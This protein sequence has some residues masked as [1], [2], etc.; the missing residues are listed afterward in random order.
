MKFSWKKTGALILAV[1]FSAA[2]SGCSGGWKE[3]NTHPVT[4]VSV[5]LPHDSDQYWEYIRLSLEEKKEEAKNYNIDINI[6]KPQMNY[7]ISQ[8]TEIL[9]KQIAAKADFIVVQGN[10]DPEFNEVLLGAW[11]EGIHIVCV[12]T[13][14]E[15]FPEHLY[16]GTDNYRAGKLLGEELVKLTGGKAEVAIL[17][18][19]EQYLNMKER[20]QGF[21]D[22][23]EAYPEVRLGEL[24]YD[25]YDG[26]T[27]MQLFYELSAGADTLVCLEGTGGSTIGSVYKGSDGEYRY[28]VGFDAY[29]GVEKGI[30]D[31]II[32]QDTSQMG[33]C[34]VDEIIRY[35]T[36][37]D[38]SSD[39][40]YTDIF[41]LT[42]E[43]YDE[44]M[45]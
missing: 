42:A 44:V 11:E 16:V 9:R 29:E 6:L 20:Y 33:Y 32:R 17:S 25:H 41:W 23:V 28:I 39:R 45:E 5:I 18:G 36:G 38:Y 26:L 13:D 40:I 15:D 30:L 24:R 37:G 31:G 10:E 3:E 21:I 14:I 22:A 1:F 8:M 34:I 2:V 12:D 27:V 4:R 7:N 43:N 35:V 19:E